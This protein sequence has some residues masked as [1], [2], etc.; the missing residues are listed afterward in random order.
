M[1]EISN[2][3][4]YKINYIIQVDQNKFISRSN[5]R[6]IS[7]YGL[8]R[9]KKIKKLYKNQLNNMTFNGVEK[10]IFSPRNLKSK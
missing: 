3:V 7:Y 4:S 8:I 2:W 5:K 9:T 6:K 1:L 10:S